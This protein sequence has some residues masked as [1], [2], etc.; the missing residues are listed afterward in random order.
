MSQDQRR[1]GQREKVALCFESLSLYYSCTLL[2]SS[3]DARHSGGDVPRHPPA[4]R[5]DEGNQRPGRVRGPVH[6]DAPRH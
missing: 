1:G 4:G 6:R 2:V 5:P 3:G